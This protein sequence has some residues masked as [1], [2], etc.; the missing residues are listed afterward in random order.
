ML[1][2]KFKYKYGNEI[3]LAVIAVIICLMS[4]LHPFAKSLPRIDSSVFMYI[5][6]QMLKGQVPYRDMFDHKGP[7]LYIINSLGMAWGNGLGI[8]VIEI[9]SLYISSLFCYKTGKKLTSPKLA[10]IATLIVMIS[11]INFFEGGNLTE[12]YALPFIFISLYCFTDCF[13]NNFRSSK[14]KVFIGGL[15]FGAVLMIRPNMISVWLAF[16]PVILIYL[17]SVKRYKMLNR[18]I[19]FFSLG[20]ATIVFP[21]I[22]YL[23]SNNALKDFVYQYIIFNFKYADSSSFIN[24]LDVLKYFISTNTMIL[25]TFLY[26]IL[27]LREKKNFSQEQKLFHLSIVIFF[28]VTYITVIMSGR[29]YAHY[30]MV[31][32]PTSIVPITIIL[33][34]IY[35]KVQIQSIQKD[36]CKFVVFTSLLFSLGCIEIWFDTTVNTFKENKEAK[37]ISELIKQYTEEDDSISVFGND[38]KIYLMTDR[39][40]SSKYIY[41]TPPAYI[42]KEVMEEYITQLEQEKPKVIVVKKDILQK[43]TRELDKFINQFISKYYECVQSTKND[44]I[45]LLK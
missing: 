1:E 5:G 18:Y 34:S 19:I 2:R 20:M 4:P 14:Y 13:M 12:E 32:L 10:L 11:L 28:I 17:L 31:I 42:S 36:I 8:W 24:T 38:V 44:N 3:V 7:L 22:L 6:N 45:Y 35:N 41:Q 39:K 25:S 33:D 37:K 30:G 27:V 16:C 40:S 26:F 29:K 21:L 15:C 43:N 9:I 23:L